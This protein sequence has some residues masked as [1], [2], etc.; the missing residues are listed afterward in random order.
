MVQLTFLANDDWIDGPRGIPGQLSG[1]DDVVAEPSHNP[2]RETGVQKEGVSGFHD[3]TGRAWPQRDAV[4]LC[5]VPHQLRSG[6]VLPTA[7]THGAPVYA[8][9]AGAPGA[10]TTPAAHSLYREGGEAPAV[11]KDAASSRLL[12]SLPETTK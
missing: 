5:R 11:N 12:N 7:P 9:P 6:L 8:A 4:G 3:G 10:D 1:L 2:G